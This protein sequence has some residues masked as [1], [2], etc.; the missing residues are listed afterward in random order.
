MWL[1]LVL[2]Y[3]KFLFMSVCG[4]GV[5]YFVSGY[6]FDEGRVVGIFDC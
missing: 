3:L 5:E 2:V 4:L 1:Y 6:V